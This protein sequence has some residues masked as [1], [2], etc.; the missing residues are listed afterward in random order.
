MPIQEPAPDLV[1]AYNGHRFDEK[2]E[3]VEAAVTNV[4]SATGRNVI[5]KT[6][7]LTVR[8]TII[9][10]DDDE[11]E[12]E[13]L[14]DLRARLM[15]PG[16]ELIVVGAGVGDLA[17]NVMSAGSHATAEQAGWGMTDVLWGPRPQVT[18]V[19]PF[20]AGVS[21]E[22]TWVCSVSLA[23]LPP[24]PEGFD[25]L[26]DWAWS[27][28]VSRDNGGYSTR[29]IAGHVRCGGRLDPDNGS[30]LIDHA[31]RLLERIAPQLLPGF[32]RIGPDTV[33]SEAKDR[34]NFTF[35]DVQFPSP[36]YP[37]PGVV[38]ISASHSLTCSDP[39]PT[40]WA[41]TMTGS[42]EMQLG[43]ARETAQQHFNLLY[44]DRIED[45]MRRQATVGGQRQAIVCIPNGATISEPEI[46]GKLGAS[47]TY[48]YVCLCDLH[49]LLAGGGALWRPVPG[50][51]WTRWAGS[52]KDGAFHVRGTAKLGFKADSDAI[53]DLCS[54]A[55]PP[56][57][58]VTV[59][60]PPAARS[61]GLPPAQIPNPPKEASWLRWVL[62]LRVLWN[63]D[64][65][66][67][68]PLPDRRVPPPSPP[69]WQGPP[70]QI[71]NPPGGGGGGGSLRDFDRPSGGPAGSLRDFDRPAGG[72]VG[73]FAVGSPIIQ[74]RGEPVYVAVLSGY[75]RRAGSPIQTPNLVSVGGVPAVPCGGDVSQAEV[76][77]WFG[78]PIYQSSWRLYFVLT[79]RP[80]EPAAVPENRMRG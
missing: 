25:G 75:A 9:S 14:E 61:P 54:A 22:I 8:E 53:L 34:L 43:V 57:P 6:I 33:L 51:D 59:I 20:G 56:K 64:L 63:W 27:L 44:K 52:L 42:Y 74:S 5:A 7:T 40:R 50:G 69:A 41:G 26:L 80:N 36:N 60:A 37:P 30:R 3:L 32:R 39:V 76:S 29:R 79:G 28:A 16:K 71:P 73:G 18:R 11:T 24:G 68:L 55:P 21:A 13:I 49:S 47:F 31:D 66:I 23:C 12:D 17:V 19:K 72:S 48:N 4:W 35:T 70:A 15:E 45:S 58:G 62:R 1:I 65:A 46:Y 77:N 2:S 78:V 38:N 10:E 67:H